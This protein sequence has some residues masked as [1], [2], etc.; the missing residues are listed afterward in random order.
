GHARGRQSPEPAHVRSG[1]DAVRPAA[2]AG[3]AH[4]DRGGRE[5]AVAARGAGEAARHAL[6]RRA[7]G[8]GL[9]HEPRP[10]RDPGH[11]GGRRAGLGMIAPGA[12]GPARSTVVKVCGIT[13]P[14]DATWA[15]DCGADWLGFIVRG[16][17]PRLIGAER[18]AAIVD[19]AR[20]ALPERAWTAV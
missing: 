3:T 4:G 9:R 8:R 5:R 10:R 12:R 18:A 7:D 14:E 1:H 16:E 20:Q 15:L 13:R 11:A 17:S 2:A 19:A 6:R